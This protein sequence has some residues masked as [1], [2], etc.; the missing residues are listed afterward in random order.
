M[1][2]M[3]DQSILTPPGPETIIHSPAELNRAVRLHLEAGFPT[4]WIRGELSNLACPASG[5][6]YFSLKDAAAQIRCAMF[7]KQS[8]QLGFQPQNGD[9]VLVRGRLS[10]YEARGDY[11]LIADGMLPAGLG[12]WQQAFEALKQK[13]K[14]E[15]LFAAERK[16]SLPA[17]PQ[18]LAVVTSPTG[19][20]L[21]DILQVLSQRWPLARVR[22]YPAQVQG[23][24]AVAEIQRALKAADQD[25]FADLILL[26][27]G[28]GSMEDLWAFND[29]S[30]ARQIAAMGTPLVSG[31]GHETDLT[32]ADFVADLRAPTPSAA[33][34][35]ATPD[36]PALA[37]RLVTLQQRAGAAASRYLDRQTQGLDYLQRRL[38]AHSPERRL[39]DL[40]ARQGALQQRLG[41][42]I[43]VYLRQLDQQLRSIRARFEQE[44]P[45]RR[46]QPL[47]ER[48]RSLARRLAMAM[49]YRL[50]RAHAQL[51]KQ[52]RALDS[53]SP[54]RVLDR[55]Y[56]VVCD[57][58]GAALTRID[59]FRS[60]QPVKLL[61]RHFEVSAQITDE[62]T[63]TTRPRFER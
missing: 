48:R 39:Q 57:Q 1:T 62:P 50:D 51:G 3:P 25:G 61:F 58:T 44:N 52:T 27:R 59:Q 4:I 5:H 8:G 26:A 13:L 53:L 36:G 40:L 46:L 63:E 18:R 29:E 37:H 9:Q 41:R 31:I 7:R 28:G 60:A 54:L 16:R 47:N 49:E 15:G 14:S 35:A 32:I 45:V 11:Q 20:A 34:V 23:E 43:T 12:D 6:L 33:A 21:R 22:I 10:L 55:G 17:W 24:Q 19:A 56:A 42:S 30:L 2:H 38:Q